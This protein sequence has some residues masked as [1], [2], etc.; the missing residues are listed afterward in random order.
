MLWIMDTGS[1]Q[2]PMLQL[3][4]TVS[5]WRV[6]FP[7][8]LAPGSC[9]AP[10]VLHSRTCL[11]LVACPEKARI[12]SSGPLPVL[13]NSHQ[14]VVA[15]YWCSVPRKLSQTLLP[16]RHSWTTCILLPQ[17]HLPNSSVSFIC[18][19]C[20]PWTL[21]YPVSTWV[22]QFSIT[23]TKYSR[24]SNRLHHIWEETGEE[25]SRSESHN[26]LWTHPCWPKYS[27]IGPASYRGPSLLRMGSWEAFKIWSFLDSPHI[28]A[29]G[30]AS[31][32]VKVLEDFQRPES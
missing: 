12:I 29:A 19:P 13:S 4:S 25:E 8:W 21:T 1:M 31:R 18:K 27:S 10:S 26:A 16:K 15:A 17:N 7:L 32:T 22:Q 30:E 28:L 9:F 2:S 6:R 5:D 11:S 24:E 20:I 14:M 23:L 3:G